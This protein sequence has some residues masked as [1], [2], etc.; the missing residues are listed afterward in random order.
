MKSSEELPIIP[1]EAA[2][3]RRD[4]HRLRLSPYLTPHFE[5][6]TRGV[7]HPVYD[8]L[9]DYYSFRASQLIRWTPGVDGRVHFRGKLRIEWPDHFQVRESVLVFDRDALPVKRIPFLRW[10]VNFLRVTRD[11]PPV[12]HCF[13]M[14]EWAMLYRTDARRYPEIPLRISPMEL[15]TMIDSTPLCCSHYDALRFFSP[16]ARP[17]NRTEI[18]Q[19][20]IAEHDQPGCL[21][22]NMD[23]Y[24][25]AYKV[26]P[27]LPSELLADL[28]VLAWQARELDMQASPYDLRLYGIEPVP[29]ETKEGRER[30]VARQR[31]IAYKAQ[32][33]RARLLAAFERLLSVVEGV[34][35]H[36]GQVPN[37][38]L[39]DVG[40]P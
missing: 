23:L 4:A 29:L 40:H 38:T 24:R 11:R 2:I 31:E 18:G 8:F 33:E 17:L 16:K 36:V 3:A 22:A 35:G 27:C 7:E 13:G 25:L 28:F 15:D 6:R 1:E 32:P 37:D 34:A 21:H 12:F 30:Y 20:E 14:H 26:A 5:R 10:A 19:K 9:F 39:E